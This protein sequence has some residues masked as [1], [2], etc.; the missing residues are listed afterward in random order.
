[1]PAILKAT[2]EKE[3]DIPEFAQGQELYEERDG[4]W[5]L[6]MD[7]IEGVKTIADVERVQ[8]GLTQE[9]KAHKELK[10]KFKALD[11]HDLD[12]VVEKIGKYDEM[13]AKVESL[14]GGEN[15]EKIQKRI[16]AV[17]ASK[18]APLERQLEQLTTERDGLN[19]KNTE[20]TGTITRNQIAQKV[21]DAA[22]T[23][24]VE[25]HALPDVLLWSEKLFEVEEDGRVVTRDNIDGV[26]PGVEPDV[27]LA[28]MQPK[29]PGWW[30]RSV[31]GGAEGGSGDG[32]S[33]KNPFS[34]TQWN[35][36]EQFRVQAT[37]ANKAEQLAKSAGFRDLGEAVRA[38]APNGQ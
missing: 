4:K 35:K 16:D 20:L 32:V 6:K 8:R 37:D 12:E 22:V 30:P 29:R 26:T 10:E 3:E 13:V 1:M 19:A 23:A 27:W 2:Y 5:L 15:E 36:T 17:V 14:E 28:E 34:K 33:T 9:K 24:K 7:A 31:G 18:V 38:K 21:R 11:G 25:S